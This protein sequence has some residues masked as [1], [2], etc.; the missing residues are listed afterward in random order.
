MSVLDSRLESKDQLLDKYQE[1]YGIPNSNQ[2]ALLAIERLID[3]FRNDELEISHLTRMHDKIIKEHIEKNRKILKN[4]ETAEMHDKPSRPL[5]LLY[6]EA[7]YREPENIGEGVYASVWKAKCIVDGEWYAIKCI[8]NYSD[9]KWQSIIHEAKILARLKHDNIIR[10][11][12]PDVENIGDQKWLFIRMQ[13]GGKSLDK[14]NQEKD[15]EL[16]NKINLCDEISIRCNSTSIERM[17][18]LIDVLLGLQYLHNNRLVH[19]DLHVGNVFVTEG[20]AL[21]G[22]FGLSGENMNIAE[23]EGE[24]IENREPGLLAPPS[25][26]LP[27]K[28]ESDLTGF[29]EIYFAT[30]YMCSP[31]NI[32]LGM[33]TSPEFK[34]PTFVTKSDFDILNE[35]YNR[36]KKGN[37]TTVSNIIKRDDIQ[38]FIVYKEQASRLKYSEHWKQHH[39]PILEDSMKIKIVPES[40]DSGDC[41]I[42]AMYQEDRA[43]YFVCEQSSIYTVQ[44]V[45]LSNWVEGLEK[46]DGKILYKYNGENESLGK[47]LSGLFVKNELIISIQDRCLLILLDK[48]NA[49]NKLELSLFNR[50]F[51]TKNLHPHFS[52]EVHWYEAE[53]V[54]CFSIKWPQTYISLTQQDCLLITHRGSK[55]I[56]CIDLRS[57]RTTDGFKLVHTKPDDIS[58]RVEH[59]GLF[60]EGV[61]CMCYVPQKDQ[62]LLQSVLSRD[63][64][65]VRAVFEVYH[66]SLESGLVLDFYIPW[67]CNQLLQVVVP[68]CNHFALLYEYTFDEKEDSELQLDYELPFWEQQKC[69]LVAWGPYDSKD[70]VAIGVCYR[71][72]SDI[73][74]WMQSSE[75]PV[76]SNGVCSSEILVLHVLYCDNLIDREGDDLSDS[77]SEERTGFVLNRLRVSHLHLDKDLLPN[78]KNCVLD[79]LSS[80]MANIS[81]VC[82]RKS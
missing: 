7:K 36:S 13:L 78:S 57:M 4:A 70:C 38:S 81:L 50:K 62:I 48:S 76:F 33:D 73:R 31:D 14:W 67:D 9:K 34:C 51:Q 75:P 5:E 63:P 30:K 1:E 55:Y 26:T 52:A 24:R 21:I 58:I 54:G 11:Y 22:D 25:N 37:A 64:T 72:E 40:A 77:D 27:L 66:Y 42:I 39:I 61:S 43:L 49:L 46:L 35:L 10:Y 60:T 28:F 23:N 20:R 69:E 44:N 15:E 8:C 79:K 68:P 82:T 71:N 18:I 47:G 3:Y 56:F 32:G 6:L 74:C 19:G 41:D 65:L 80:A 45:D 2:R 29:G 17:C 59:I 53:P 16:A 12:S